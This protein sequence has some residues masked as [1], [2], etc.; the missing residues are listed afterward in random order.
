LQTEYS[1]IRLV[2]KEFVN[3]IRKELRTL[4]QSDG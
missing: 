2:R 1:K 3:Q 4:L